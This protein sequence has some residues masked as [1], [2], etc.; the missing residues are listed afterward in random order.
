MGLGGLGGVKCYEVPGQT[1]IL[2]A[3]SQQWCQPVSLSEVQHLLPPFV[4]RA[5]KTY[6]A[7]TIWR[8]PGSVYRL[9]LEV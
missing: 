6:T 3:D 7:V 5:R 4:I 2:L 1:Y 9:S 8:L